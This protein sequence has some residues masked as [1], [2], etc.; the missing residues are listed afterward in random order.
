MLAILA[1]SLAALAAWGLN[2]IIVRRWGDAAISVL[3]PVIEELLKTLLAV[4]FSASI[5]LTHFT[6]GIIEAIWDIK[7]NVRGLRAGLVGL[8]THSGFG[9]ITWMIYQLTGILS[10]ALMASITAH[11][12]WNS[13]IIQ[14]GNK[15]K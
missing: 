6:F 9:L 15:L 12:T 10:L 2:S 14:N 7:A 4:M 11:I 13:I 3:V 8:L 5:F 1:G